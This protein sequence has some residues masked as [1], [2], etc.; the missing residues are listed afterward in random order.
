MVIS[1]YIY[2]PVVVVIV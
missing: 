1:C 2:G